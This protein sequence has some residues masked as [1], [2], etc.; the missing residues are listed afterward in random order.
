MAI[1]STIK[2]KGRAAMINILW[3][4]SIPPKYITIAAIEDKISPQIILTVF[5]GFNCPPVVNIPSTKVAESAVVR[6]NI[7]ITKIVTTDKVVPNG[8]CSYILNVTVSVASL[9]IYVMAFCSAVNAATPKTEKEMMVN[10]VGANK[11]PA[12]NCRMVRPLDTR[13]I[14]IPTN[15]AYEIHQAQ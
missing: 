11:T 8:Y 12:I 9:V 4:T 3:N 7:E 1:N 14:N 13:A 15:G 6:K 10:S 2:E 5:G